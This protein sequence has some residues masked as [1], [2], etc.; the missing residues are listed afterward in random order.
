MSQPT[1]SQLSLLASATMFSFIKPTHSD[2]LDKIQDKIEATQNNIK[3]HYNQAQFIA[4]LFGYTPKSL[5]ANLN[6]LLK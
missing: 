3:H 5:A 6:L 4:G 2:L 1:P